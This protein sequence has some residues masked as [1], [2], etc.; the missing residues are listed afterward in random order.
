MWPTPMRRGSTRRKPTCSYRRAIASAST[1]LLIATLVAACTIG[2]STRPPLAISESGGTAAIAPQTTSSSMPTG[3]GGAGRPSD[4]VQWSSCPDGIDTNGPAGGATF[5]LQCAEVEVPK[6][7]STASSGSLSVALAKATTERTPKDA[8][9][10]L[11]VLG[12]P[13]QNGTHRIA[14]VAGVLPTA[15]TDRFAVIVMDLRGTGDSV[16][17]DCVSGQSSGD[18]LSLGAD[19]TTPVAADLVAGLARTVTFDCGDMVGP[20]L[21][22]YSSVSAADDIDT[23]R[24]ALGTR[25]INFLGRGFGATLGAVYADRYP[26]RI[27]ASVLD[28]PADPS[29]TPKD[30]ANAAA[31]GYQS[32]LTSFGQACQTFSGGCP[33]GTDVTGALT[34]TVKQLGDIGI[35]SS[36][37]QE[38][39]GGSILLALTGELG[40]P[41]GWPALAAALESAGRGDTDAIATLLR[42]ELGTGSVEQQQ[43]GRL[44]YQ[45]N[46][47]AQ[48]LGGTSLA[49]AVN[50]ARSKAPLF[51]PFLLGLVG[52]CSSWPA[53]DVGLT[54]VRA[55]GAPPIL[56]LGAVDDPVS[57]ISEV[58]SLVAQM[59]SAVLLS[60]QSGTHGAFPTS[61]C[62]TA[63]VGA[64]LV[65]GTVPAAGTLCPP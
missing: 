56:V 61:S 3:P 64:Y 62:V 41:A 30:Q 10:L 59:D 60:W 24:A 54:G 19:P 63:A 1:V 47:S 40:R 55:T 52:V 16:P 9:P 34:S 23:V 14:S 26:G 20:D 25:T 37:G 44:V 28:G 4:P 8:P 38:I 46:D 2:P 29:S 7:Y 48:R 58:R 17:I 12:S 5:T 35:P 6:S 31:A 39:T 11:V 27:G 53:P 21:T 18:L 50:A 51:G 15:I 57:P 49:A 32:A 65:A 33:L 13:G 22:D 43:S 45:C 36:D 42:A